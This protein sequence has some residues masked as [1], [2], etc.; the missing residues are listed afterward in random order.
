MSKNSTRVSQHINAPRAKVYRALVDAAARFPVIIL[1]MSV[2]LLEEDIEIPYLL[3]DALLPISV[4]LLE[5][6]K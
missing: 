1:F 4:L 5:A 2:L 6:D 3:F